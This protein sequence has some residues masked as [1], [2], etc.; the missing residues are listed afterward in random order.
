[1]RPCGSRREHP[2]EEAHQRRSRSASSGRGR[3]PALYGA[4]RRA[5]PR[6]CRCAVPSSATIE[7][8]T[9]RQGRLRAGDDDLDR[10]ATVRKLAR[11]TGKPRKREPHWSSQAFIPVSVFDLGQIS[12][13]V[14]R[15]ACQRGLRAD[16][17]QSVT[18]GGEAGFGSEATGEAASRI[19][20]GV[21]EIVERPGTLY[22]TTTTIGRSARIRSASSCRRTRRLVWGP[23][24]GADCE[25][26]A[27]WDVGSLICW[28]L[29]TRSR[30]SL[31]SLASDLPSLDRGQ[32]G[33]WQSCSCTLPAIALHSSSHPSL[34]SARRLSDDF[35]LRDE[36]DGH[37]LIGRG[38]SYDPAPDG[39]Y[40]AGLLSTVGILWT[41]ARRCCRPSASGSTRRATTTGP[42]C[43][44]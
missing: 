17:G 22:N 39:S 30:G 21:T 40:L 16:G 42:T 10:D 8:W 23:G 31:C 27:G 43:S 25:Q 33:Q 7:E 13:R 29:L 9:G 4:T 26:Y 24:D 5:L 36:L 18:V 34:T 19:V 32:Q 11:L 20:T 14:G 3:G 28:E 38:G 35:P 6:R 41:S 15:R 37:D 2:R 12:R 44:V 1:V